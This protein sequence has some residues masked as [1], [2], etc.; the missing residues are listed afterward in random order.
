MAPLAE[1]ETTAERDLVARL[2]RGDGGAFDLVFTAYRAR[3]NGFLVRMSSNRHLAED[4]VQ[5]TFLRL[6]RSAR[7]LADDTQ[8][9]PWLFT[10]ARNLYVSHCRRTA[11]DADRVYELALQAAHREEAPASPHDEYEG[12]QLVARFE[13]ALAELPPSYRE[14]ILLT[15]VEQ[16][17]PIEAAKV[18][19]LS[20]EAL[21]QRLSRARALLREA[22][23]LDLQPHK[24]SRSAP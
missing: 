12:S 20:S 2:Q 22:L 15:A 13:R 1:A 4:L 11:L 17:E 21:R 14:V 3:I 23:A 18:L 9:K 8:L 5:E 19:E 6:A 24:R 16:M 10:V 7:T